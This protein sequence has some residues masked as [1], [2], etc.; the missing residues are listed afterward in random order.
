MNRFTFCLT[1]L[2]STTTTTL[3]VDPEPLIQWSFNNDV[4]GQVH[5]VAT[6]RAAGLEEPRYP[7]FSKQNR[8]LTLEAPSWLQIPDDIADGR[9][10]FDNGDAVTFEAWVQVSSLNDNA[11]IVGKGRT[12]TSGTKTL[13]QN[14]AFRLRRNKGR[15]CVNFL[16]H[17]RK[18]ETGNGDWHRWTSKTGFLPGSRWH[19]VAVGYRFGEPKSIRGFIDGK[20]VNG[21]WDMGGETTEPPVVDD[22]DVWIGSTMGGNRGNS[23]H[24][25][26]DELRIHRHEVPSDELISRYRWNPPDVKPPLVPAGKVV[27]Q[28]FGSVESVSQI[29]LETDAPLTEWTQ[30]DMGF[31]RLPHKYDSW[32]IREDWGTTLLVRAWTEIELTAGDYRLLSRSRGLSRLTVD[33]KVLLTTAPQPNRGGAHHVV[34][35]LPEVPFPGMRPHW[36]SDNEQVVAFSSEG[37]K[38]RVMYEVIVG[39]PSYRA[40]FG[41]TC[42]AIAPPHGMFHIL[43]QLSEYPLTDDGWMAFVDQQSEQLDVLDRH[44]RQ[45]ANL[46]YADYWNKRHDHARKTLLSTNAHLSIDELIG[47]R[48]AARNRKSE[49]KK[50]NAD[51]TFF[52]E[53]IQP[54]FDA[55][56]IRCHGRKEQGD[57]LIVDRRRLLTGGESGEPAVV[58]GSPED[59]YLFQLVGAAADD[60]RMPPKGAGLTKDELTKVEKWIADGATMPESQVTPVSLSPIVDDHTFLRRVYIDTVGVPPSLAEAQEFLKADSANRRDKVIDHLLNDSRWADNWVGYWQ[61]ALAENPNLLKPMLNNT[62]PFRWWIHE[63]LTDNKSID[64]FATELML[65][66]GSAW[67]GGTAGFS[68]ASQNDV[69]MAAKAH[70]IGSAFLGVNMKCARCHDAPYHAWK[71][72]DLFQMA[73]MLD[74]KDLKLPTTSTVPAAFFEKQTRKSLIEV[75]LKPG[76]QISAHFPFEHLAPP[77]DRELLTRPDDSRELLAAQITASRR[78]A[79]V[80]ANRL[81]QRLMG[82]GLVDPV[83]DWEGSPASDPELLAALA[84]L[85]ITSD[86]NVK[87][88]ARSVFSS[89]AYQRAA[90]DLP[91]D[92]LPCFEGPYRRRMT[93]EQIVDSAFHAAGQQMD[94]EP[95]TMDI[96]GTL[97][98]S[99]FLNF[100]RPRRSWEFTSLA[101]ERDRPSLALPR[102]QAVADVLKAFGWRNS[103]PE[104]TVDR[105]EMPNLI[106]PGVL[107]NGTL[108]IWL[109]RLSDHS[110]LTRLMMQPQSVDE[111]TDSLFLQLLTRVPTPK[112][113]EQFTALLTPG[114]R[115]RVVPTE[116]VGTAPEQ[117]RFRYVSWSNHLNSEA[118]VIKMEIQELVRQGPPP[119]RYL[120]AEWRE[121]AED[122]VWSL[123]NSPEMILVP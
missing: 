68:L 109:T 45:T 28:L 39:G 98:A 9:Y 33:G 70:V 56:C 55:H 103:R 43:S 107:A 119:T 94:T 44:T 2:L 71:Q 34:D 85:L 72:A 6:S 90:V 116:D 78:F 76:E 18:T 87:E 38:H 64:R 122:A 111:L 63:A 97:T 79:E 47:R 88:F 100:G 112:E 23:F 91:A 75:S 36:M 114:F 48:I 16:F 52:Q 106:Q 42:V 89:H 7:G 96:E 25:S 118:N 15:A 46:T 115:D 59:S 1:V 60:Y 77:V 14:W 20:E 54:V 61:D 95:L 5:G 69:P 93:A 83:D 86:Y 120:R 51:T 31:V 32:G 81:W 74:R 104:P 101:N 117:K 53:H 102:A 19:H 62:G 121:R 4:P 13:N 82:A 99:R 41:E 73:A 110:G 40:E 8:V 65:M 29:P 108:G 12:E 37:G 67:N 30:D 17:S 49:R 113:R 24:G 80:I 21:S 3:A 10:D 66:R 105:E 57:L 35:E 84:D 50:Q 11:Y 26:I 27:V 22:D 123:L 58:P 92:G